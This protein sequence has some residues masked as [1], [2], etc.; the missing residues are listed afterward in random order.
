VIRSMRL[1]LRVDRLREEDAPT[2]TEVGPSLEF[3]VKPLLTLRR[4]AEKQPDLAKSRVP[5]LTIGY[6]YF[7]SPGAAQE[8]ENRVVLEASPRLPVFWKV[9][10]TERN[11]GQLRVIAG[12]FSW[13]Y[14]NRLTLERAIRVSSH[15]FSPFLRG[16]GF[17]DSNYEKW[18]ATALSAGAIFPVKKHIELEP[19]LQHQN[20]TASIP[21]RHVETLGVKFSLYF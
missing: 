17:Y 9:L 3:S 19:C 16:E 21:N 12:K 7:F 4:L 14:R 20:Q 11:R 13:R 2:Q 10:L 6:R 8:N 15:S 5:T 18:S 1:W